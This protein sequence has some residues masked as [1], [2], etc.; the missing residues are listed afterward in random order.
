[1]LYLD[2]SVLVAYY[3]PE[4]MLDIDVRLIAE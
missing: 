1:M 3:C 2:T 4:E